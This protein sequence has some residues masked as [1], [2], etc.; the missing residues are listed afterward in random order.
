M[1][2]A[3]LYIAGRVLSIY[4]GSQSYTQI[5]R[6]HGLSVHPV[7]HSSAPKAG[8]GLKSSAH[9]GAATRCYLFNFRHSGF[10]YIWAN[11]RPAPNLTATNNNVRG[12]MERSR[13]S[14]LYTNLRNGK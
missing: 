3:N 5:A 6:L 14:S 1:N 10:L 9:A 2:A 13:G 11:Q 12:R 4:S 7:T 8:K